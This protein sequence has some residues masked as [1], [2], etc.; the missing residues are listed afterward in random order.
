MKGGSTL[1]E[2]RKTKSIIGETRLTKKEIF[3]F[4]EIYLSYLNEKGS[5]KIVK[6]CNRT[7]ILGHERWIE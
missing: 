7:D 5:E 4:D 3:S 2:T 1:I 6:F